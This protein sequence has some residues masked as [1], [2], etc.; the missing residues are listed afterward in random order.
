MISTECIHGRR[1]TA[2]ANVD[3]RGRV[4]KLLVVLMCVLAWPVDGQ[5]S[6]LDQRLEVRSVRFEGNAA[7]D[8]L[9]LRNAIATSASS[10]LR[11][12]GLGERRY[13][14]ETEFRRDVLRIRAFYRQSGFVDVEV[15][16]ALVRTPSEVRITF[17]ISEGVPIVVTSI[18][19]QGL[20]AVT[21]PRGLL[22]RLPLREGRPF[23]RLR[24][25]ASADSL[26]AALADLGHPFAEVY[27][28]FDED[29]VEREA[30]VYFVVDPGPRAVIGD[31]VVVGARAIP[32]EAVRRRLLLQPGK[33]Y[34]ERDVYASQ[35]DL[36]RSNLYN[37]VTIRLQDSVP[38]RD[39]LV[40]LRVRVV[41]SALHRIRLGAGYGTTDCFRTSGQWE[42]NNFF[43]GGRQFVVGGRLSR[44]GVGGAGGFEN[45][46][47]CS[48]LADDLPELLTLNYNLSASL[49]QPNL[50]ARR[51][52]ATVTV[53]GERLSEFQAY[54][55]DAIGSELSL[56]RQIGT[57]AAVTVGYGLVQGRTFTDPAKQCAFLNVCSAAD[58]IFNATRLTSRV[59]LS[60]LRDSRNSVFDP[61]RGSTLRAEVAF[62]SRALGSD[63][64]SQFF[65]ASINYAQYQRITRGHTLA[66]RVHVGGQTVPTL[67]F[68]GGSGRIAPPEERFYAGGVTTVRGY[69]QNGLG[70][71]VHVLEE[72]VDPT[73]AAD[74]VIRT[75]PVGGNAVFYANVEYRFPLAT[76]GRVVGAV[77][78]DVGEV[79]ESGRNAIDGFRVTPGAGVRIASPLGPV[80]FDVAYNPHGPTAGRLFRQTATGLDAV[81][82]PGDGLYRP[83]AHG[84]VL[85]RLRL[86]FSI[87]QAF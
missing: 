10:R 73:G 74:S 22:D 66:W 33:L 60:F 5:E 2:D 82:L 62:A 3:R 63:S 7:I 64:L 24:L 50:L 43:G 70:P 13:L 6:A 15:D 29:R 51:T 57:R 67:Q 12:V 47:I 53:F 31:I 65:K 28:N 83:A 35:L 48:A 34:R 86:H 41:E 37:S 49:S 39:S 40:T 76:A 59:A 54:R 42:L 79:F 9:V 11:A 38:P 27:T 78:V 77:F 23:D 58:T 45:K 4:V 30:T 56:T 69:A 72:I 55:R 19:V 46:V 14:N 32:P 8:D 80:R 84:G 18:A 61:T 81:A 85:G 20:E 21:T 25:R 52:R 26:E 1:R 68:A 87:G 17:T 44:L 71:V 75:S 16:T 36:Y